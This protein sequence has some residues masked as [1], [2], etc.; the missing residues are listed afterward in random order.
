MQKTL[1]AKKLIV[2]AILMITGTSVWAKPPQPYHVEMIIFERGAASSQLEYWPNDIELKY[3]ADIVFIQ[4]NREPHL[5]ESL[6][7]DEAI[8]ASSSEESEL[9]ATSKAISAQESSD[10]LNPRLL[11]AR[12]HSQFIL[13]DEAAKL[14]KHYRVIFHQAWQ[15]TFTATDK[16]PFIVING[17][18]TFDNRTELGGSVR[19]SI[20]KFIHLDTNLWYAKFAPNLGQTQQWPMPPLTPASQI[21]PISDENPKWQ[22]TNLE[23]PT[24]GITAE[25]INEV[26]GQQFQYEGLSAS[27]NGFSSALEERFD[28]L[29]E[30]VYSLK[31]SRKLRSKELHYIDHPRFGIILRIDPISY[32]EVISQ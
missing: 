12:N 10:F 8:T 20:N 24:L 17:G 18:D 5:N 26:G 6:E 9:L 25:A 28:F 2:A 31:Q 29:P 3:P 1:S 19:L 16:A 32:E 30:T 14:S 21:A 13:D 23:T 22:M 11:K 7:S 4:P 15:Q 27:N